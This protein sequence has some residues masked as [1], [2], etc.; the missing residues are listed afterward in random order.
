MKKICYEYIIWKKK[1]NHS[2]PLKDCPAK[3]RKA[4][5]GYKLTLT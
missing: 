5:D 4:G 2:P 1:I 3:W